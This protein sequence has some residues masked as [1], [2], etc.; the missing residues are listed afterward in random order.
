MIDTS[1]LR[2]GIRDYL[3][4]DTLSIYKWMKNSDI[5]RW[6]SFANDPPSKTKISKY[7]FNQIDN[8]ENSRPKYKNFVLFDIKDNERNY[9]G[10]VGL[11]NIDYIGGSAEI[12]IVISDMRYISKGYG[13]E[14]LY[15]ICHYGFITIGLQ[16]IYIHFLSH[17]IGARRAYL[18]FGFKYVAMPPKKVLVGKE[19][20]DEIVMSL[21][22]HSFVNKTM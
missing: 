5:T 20:C 13:Q 3:A 7:V 8:E 10:N 21:N 12:T 2:I 16:T 19:Y 11:K 15:L 6:Y 1:Q 4:S 18:K 14:A 9:I 22:I 17:N